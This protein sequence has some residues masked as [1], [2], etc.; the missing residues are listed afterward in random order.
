M[1]LPDADQLAQLPELSDGKKHQLTLAALADVDAGRTI[2]HDEM[3]TWVKS[4]FFG[5]PNSSP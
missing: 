4:I 3:R 5:R 2:S 1:S